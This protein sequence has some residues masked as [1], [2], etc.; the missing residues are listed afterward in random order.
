MRTAENTTSSPCS[1]KIV[2]VRVERPLRGA[3]W[4]YM[5]AKT[6]IQKRRTIPGSSGH[7]ARRRTCTARSDEGK[8]VLRRSLVE[9][10]GHVGAILPQRTTNSPCTTNLGR[11]EE[12][13]TNFGFNRAHWR[14]VS[15]S[16]WF[17]AL[18]IGTAT[19]LT[20][21]GHEVHR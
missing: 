21:C 17:M 11:G 14:T 20:I 16:P 8:T 4:V 2:P 5:V 15:T 19:R 7:G 18:F 12:D 9:T 10:G 6:T 1:H 3:L 13:P